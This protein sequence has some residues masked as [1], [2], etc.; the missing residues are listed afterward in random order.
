MFEDLFCFRIIILSLLTVL[1]VRYNLVHTRLKCDQNILHTA[2]CNFSK[3]NTN[4]LEF[5]D[6]IDYFAIRVNLLN[7][8]CISLQNYDESISTNI[9]PKKKLLL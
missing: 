4:I 2:V 9:F 7:E 5:R 6:T 1:C 8:I 3:T